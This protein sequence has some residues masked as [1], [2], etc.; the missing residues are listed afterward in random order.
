MR[1]A[2][3][4]QQASR[5]VSRWTAPRGPGVRAVDVFLEVA[6]RFA[7]TWASRSACSGLWQTTNR[8]GRVWA[9]RRRPQ[10]L[11]SMV[12]NILQ[13]D[14]SGIREDVEEFLDRADASLRGYRNGEPD[15]MQELAAAL[16]EYG[17]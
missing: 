2:S 8:M 6:I 5:W 16:A 15:A 10:L 3:G 14:R 11:L 7:R 1:V 12:H 4:A 9:R 13:L 17:R